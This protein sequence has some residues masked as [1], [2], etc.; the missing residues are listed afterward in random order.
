LES[1]PNY[2]SGAIVGAVCADLF[3]GKYTAV[4]LLKL[5]NGHSFR[6]NLCPTDW[7]SSVKKRPIWKRFLTSIAFSFMGV[8]A[9]FIGFG[10]SGQDNFGTALVLLLPL[11]GLVWGLQFCRFSQKVY[12]L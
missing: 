6:Y 11:I 7:P 2:T 12:P 1:D 4:D 9:D 10:I 5:Q 8:I 3:N